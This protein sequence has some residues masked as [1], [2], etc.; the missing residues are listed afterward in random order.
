MCLC[1]M[2]DH[3]RRV[4]NPSSCL[5]ISTFELCS[6]GINI[7]DLSLTVASLIQEIKTLSLP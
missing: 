6:I 4:E 7:Q 3:S 2:I 5:I 1:Y